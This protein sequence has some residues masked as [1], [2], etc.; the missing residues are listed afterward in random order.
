MPTTTAPLAH[1]P[2]VTTCHV[3]KSGAVVG[4]SAYDALSSCFT[5]GCSFHPSTASPAAATATPAP[6]TSHGPRE[7]GFGGSTAAGGGTSTR[8]AVPTGAMGC[9]GGQ[10]SSSASRSA[11]SWRLGAA[12]KLRLY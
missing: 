8:T 4:Y 1:R 2:I 6:T 11:T 3:R 9:F 10:G 12:G 5:S 7:D